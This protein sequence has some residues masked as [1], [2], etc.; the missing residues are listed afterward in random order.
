MSIPALDLR[1]T[2]YS[3]A[4]AYWLGKAARLAYDDESETKPR[5]HGGV[6]TASSSSTRNTNYRFRSTTP[7]PMSYPAST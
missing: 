1:S 3:L 4:H 5:P 2:E 6:S 7:R